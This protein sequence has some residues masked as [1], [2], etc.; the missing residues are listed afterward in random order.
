MM[1][2]AELVERGGPRPELSGEAGGFGGVPTVTGATTGSG[3]GGGTTVSSSASSSASGVGG[4]GGSGCDDA[5]EPNDS[6]AAAADL[7]KLNDCDT[8]GK[9]MSFALDG[10]GDV[11][12][13]RYQGSDDFGCVVDPTRVILAS[14]TIRICSF[15]QCVSGQISVD[16]KNGAGSSASP[17]GWPGCCHNQ[18][19][20][21]G[22]ECPGTADDADVLVR[23]D[24]GVAACTSYSL[25]YHY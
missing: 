10:P 12:W 5:L 13:Y 9:T 18:G 16:C 23:V 6:E 19:F 2:C 3:G 4:A 17:A 11:D 21:M 14:D 7:G 15:A 8:N 25:S 20:V 1:S 22:I 24:Q